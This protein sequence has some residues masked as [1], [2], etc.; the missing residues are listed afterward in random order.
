MTNANAKV[1]VNLKSGEGFDAT[2]VNVY[3]ETPQELENLLR[4]VAEY[5]PLIAEAR[6]AVALAHGIEVKQ[7]SVQ[8]QQEPPTHQPEPPQSGWG[9]PAQAAPPS[10]AQPNNAGPTCQHGPMV[11]RSGEK[12][13][14]QWSAH[15]CPTP[16]GTPG[17]CQPVF[18]K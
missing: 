5:A 18:G 6:G 10:F 2:L 17:Q 4:S 11:F 15:F 1:Q 9:Q 14:R 13:G 8:V 7:G 12:N 3:A 16:K